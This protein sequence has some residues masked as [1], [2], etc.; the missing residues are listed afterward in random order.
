MLCALVAVAFPTAASAAPRMWTGFQDDQNFRWAPDRAAVLD[1]AA[2]AGTSIIRVTIEWAQ[3]APTRPANAGNP[4]DPAYK[5]DDVDEFVRAAE[6]RGIE[7]LISIWGTPS[8]ANRGKGPN[9]APRKMKD[10]R[11]FSKALALRYSGRFSGYPF[12]RFYSLWNEPNLN[13]FLSPQFDKKGRSVAPKTYAKMFRA[14][15]A[16]IKAGNKKALVAIGETSPQG[17]DRP[18]PGAVSDSHSPGRFAQLLAQ[19]RPRLKFDAY[20]HHPYSTKVR[21]SPR[22][23]VK[24]SNVNWSQMPKFERSIDAWFKKKNIPIW[25]TEYGHQTRPERFDGLT[26]KQQANFAKQALNIAKANPRIQMFIWFIYRDSP[27]KGNE[28]ES[29]GGVVRSNNV[30]KPSLSRFIKAAKQVDARNGQFVVKAGKKNPKVEIPVRELKARNAAGATISISYSMKEGKRLLGK[31]IASGVLA[32]EG[33]VQ[34]RPKLTVKKGR[35]YVVNITLSDIN[36]NKVTRRIE[37]RSAS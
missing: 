34:F 36:G 17:R 33:T 2:A 7:V 21:F 27:T 6:A 15:Y 1:R 35:R 9:V 19:A 37:L 20:A 10:L 30:S 3:V 18:S 26:Y 11:L 25:V 16:G 22:Q 32:R 23:R 13:R 28:W 31:Y 5:L 24:W 12:V 8:W 4:F 29:A 14:A